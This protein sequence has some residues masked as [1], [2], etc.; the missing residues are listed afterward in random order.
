MTIARETAE[1]LARLGV[2]EKALAA[3]GDLSV[4]TP[5][6]GEKIAPGAVNYTEIAA[7]AIDSSHIYN[8]AVSADDLGSSAKVVYGYQRLQTANT[9]VPAGEFAGATIDCPFGKVAVGGGHWV[10][11]TDVEVVWSYA[12]DNDTWQV[13]ARNPSSGAREMVAHVICVNG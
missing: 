4:H 7:D 8:G 6:T 10:S 12:I 3:A 9:N 2:E 11:H 5:V 13:Q 1:L